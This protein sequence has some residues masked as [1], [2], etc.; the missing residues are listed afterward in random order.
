[1]KTQ[2]VLKPGWGLLYD[3]HGQMI[4][5]L[6]RYNLII[7]I[8]IP[9]FEKTPGHAPMPIIK[10]FCNLKDDSQLFPLA[11][12]VCEEVLDIYDHL[13]QKVQFYES[14]VNNLVEDRLPIML[15][16]LEDIKVVPRERR[17]Y[18]RWVS[19]LLNLGVGAVSTYLSHRRDSKLKESI[20]HLKRI[21]KRQNYEIQAIKDDLLSFAKASIDDLTAVKA[22]VS[23]Q[24]QT[25]KDAI[26]T[27]S[28][29]SYE[30]TALSIS[31]QDNK[32]AIQTI[33]T[34]LTNI[35]FKMERY[36]S[37][38]QEYITDVK[39]LLESL[40][41]LS[42]GRLP[43][44]LVN[45]NKLS[46]YLDHVK[47]EL[48]L[49]YPDF[50]LVT[51]NVENYYKMPIITS[52]YVTNMVTVQIPLFVKLKTQS[53]LF[54]YKLS[55]VPMPFHM[56][57]E[58][59]DE[60]EN[61]NTYTQIIPTSELLAM[62]DDTA[63]NLNL[64]QIN[65]CLKISNY[66]FCERLLLIKHKTHE[67]CESAIYHNCADYN[68]V[69]DMCN[70]KYYIDFIPEPQI[71]DSGEQLILSNL[72]SPWI[73]R[74][75]QREQ[76]PNTS[77]GGT[78]V[79]INK[80]DLCEC[81][82]FAGDPVWKIERNIA[83]CEDT[84]KVL[85][86]YFTYNMAVMIYQFR[87][88]LEKHSITSETLETS[89]PIWDPIEPKVINVKDKDVINQNNEPV[90]MRDVMNEIKETRYLTESDYASD[91]NNVNTWF[92]GKN[93]I[94]GILLI[95]LICFVL[96]VP[97]IL[98]ILKK[99]VKVNMDFRKI[100][101][102]LGALLG[103]ATFVKG[104]NSESDQCVEITTTDLMLIMS[105]IVGIIICMYICYRLF[106]VIYLWYNFTTMNCYQIENSLYN[107]IMFEKS[108]MYIQ[109]TTNFGA[110]LMQIKLGSYFGN[111][112]DVTLIGSLMNHDL[113]DLEKKCW[114]DTLH[115]DWRT[116]KV[117]LRDIP[118][119][120][121]LEKTLYWMKRHY[122]RKIFQDERSLYRLLVHNAESCKTRV[123][124][125]FTRLN[126]PETMY[127]TINE[128]RNRRQ[129]LTNGSLQSSSIQDGRRT[130][131][132][133]QGDNE[134]VCINDTNSIHSLP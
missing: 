12:A 22:E 3:Y 13:L 27:L 34:G 24:G 66:Y 59:I 96:L 82:I 29:L 43:Q 126:V 10:H 128:I 119:S 123:L 49:H 14:K 70:I 106:R 134:A 102:K 81:S 25:L 50:E 9:E 1:M 130:P 93:Y 107:Y 80:S 23:R 127:A 76:I 78:Y 57:E 20:G 60:T 51:E 129:F 125:D 69:K 38:Y 104:V 108:D 83:H 103:A 17:R 35:I 36:L 112:E 54:V 61:K 132:S 71:L 11:R 89:L 15:K 52:L 19:E 31:V 113:L 73:I 37:A 8:E 110:Q 45:K 86:V 21:E 33:S 87:E 6:N 53:P 79:I 117:V 95:G 46:S 77:Q 99:Y 101:T 40:E 64:D 122:I 68:H 42:T 44:G 116:F 67:T 118:I 65:Q 48:Q 62:N 85:S 74:C 90:N 98:Y 2:S 124:Y 131:P 72:P 75:E 88:E 16:Q 114:Y 55:S 18:K 63:I 92:S 97:L 109:F 41:I 28:H 115:F 58:M 26:D 7:G 39:D 120:L 30:I 5:G 133:A 4:H 84:Q 56:N 105:Q 94:F 111:P 47:R 121:P 100:N 32:H 91:M